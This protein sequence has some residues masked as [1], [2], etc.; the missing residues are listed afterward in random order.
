LR[1][2][3]TLGIIG[4]NVENDGQS[5]RRVNPADK[6]VQRKLADGNAQTADAL[7][8]DAEDALAVGDDDNVNVWIGAIAQ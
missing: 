7:I 1:I 3:Q 5:A 2:V 8:A 6:R 4:A